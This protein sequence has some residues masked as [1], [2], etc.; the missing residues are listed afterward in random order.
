[1]YPAHL[2]AVQRSFGGVKIEAGHVMAFSAGDVA[3]VADRPLVTLP[4]GTTI[5]MRTTLILY[6]ENGAWK[7]IQQHNSVGISNEE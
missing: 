3:W 5:A 2:I 1:M 6:H 4:D 7:L